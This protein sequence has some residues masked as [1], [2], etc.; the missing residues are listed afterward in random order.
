[1]WPP[2]QAA[3]GQWAKCLG[4]WKAS[5]TPAIFPLG[6][7]RLSGHLLMRLNPLLQVATVP[8]VHDPFGPPKPDVTSV[9]AR[10]GLCRPGKEGQG[11]GSS[12]LLRGSH[13]PL[14]IPRPGE[15]GSR[16]PRRA[17][18]HLSSRPRPPCTGPTSCRA[19]TPTCSPARNSSFP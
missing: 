2:G 11:R 3:I 17:G 4:T 7:R 12:E 10:R 16:R 19:P 14:Q 5:C 8:G 6:A 15:P 18:T 13:H 9:P 1:M